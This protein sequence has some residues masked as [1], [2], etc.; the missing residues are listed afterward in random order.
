MIQG[1]QEELDRGIHLAI[2][3][4]SADHLSVRRSESDMQ[5]NNLRSMGWED[6]P[7]EGPRRPEHAAFLEGA[8]GG[9]QVLLQG[10]GWLSLRVSWVLPGERAGVKR[11]PKR[12]SGGEDFVDIGARQLP[13]PRFVHAKAGAHFPT[14]SAELHI[15]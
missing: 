7:L 14:A 3:Q 4:M 12:F 9:A 10:P 1:R 5:M 13:V 6:V 2:N 8:V 11:D 15:V